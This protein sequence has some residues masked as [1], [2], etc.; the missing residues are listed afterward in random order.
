MTTVKKAAHKATLIHKQDQIYQYR[1]FLFAKNNES[2]S[3][4]D[5][6]VTTVE[7]EVSHHS[8]M[9]D[10]KVALDAVVEAHEAKLAAK[11]HKVSKKANLASIM[12]HKVDEETTEETQSIAQPKV[13]KEKSEFQALAEVEMPLLDVWAYRAK[14]SYPTCRIYMSSGKFGSTDQRELARKLAS[15]I[16]EMYGTKIVI[17]YYKINNHMSLVDTCAAGY[18][19][20]AAFHGANDLLPKSISDKTYDLIAGYMSVL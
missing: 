9:A 19:F 5:R 16:E 1:G 2:T 7:G 11:K 10:C 14:E 15:W 3:K 8:T 17:S 6:W 13:E 4:A 12:G 20:C 18:A